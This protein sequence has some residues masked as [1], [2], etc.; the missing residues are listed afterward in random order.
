MAT[1]DRPSVP[2]AAADAVDRECMT[3]AIAAAATVRCVTSPNPWVGAVLRTPDGA[4]YEGAT[5]APGRS[6]AERVALEA[7][8]EDA[9]GATLYVTLEPCDHTGRTSPCTEAIIAAG[10]ARVVVGIEDPDDQVAGRGLARLRGAGIEVTVGV[11]AEQVTNQLLAYLKHRRTGRPW[12][13]L[14]LAA[15][16]DGGTA[17]PNGTSQWI[18]SPSAR[19]D[20]H[21]L[22]AESDAILVG[23]GTV[24]RDDPSLT[25]RDYRPP[26]LPDGGSVDPR[27]VVL[28]SVAPEAKV[29]PCTEASGDLAA[30]L[31]DLGAAGVVQLLVEGGGSV[32]GDFHRAGLVDRY[33]IYLAPALFGGADA[34]GLFAGTGAYDIADLWRGRFVS[35]DRVGDDL[36]VEMAPADPRRD[37]E[38]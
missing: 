1:P 16:L 24:R 10:V 15:S 25:V 5:Q 29:Q 14:K 20:G 28:G 12:V 23:A 32:A 19:A 27:R 21:R 8:G 26:V 6:H 17:A 7:A 30:V 11:Q 4:M 18:T 37:E 13:V 31:D 33:V 9:R 35:V 34:K 2:D 36:R 3:R 38:G 22:R